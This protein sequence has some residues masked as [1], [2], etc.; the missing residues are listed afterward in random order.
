MGLWNV[1]FYHAI[2]AL[3]YLQFFDRSISILASTTIFPDVLFS[4]ACINLEDFYLLAVHV[5]HDFV[6]LPFLEAKA[7]ALVAVV[8]IVGL[9]LVVLDAD[10]I[11]VRR[12]RL[13]GEGY[14]GVDYGS[15]RNAFESPGLKLE[16]SASL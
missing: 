16:M 10:E 6:C 4:S 15:F 11:R 14:E 13:E 1:L 9:I 2:Y 12:C 7:Y 5:L 8:L 3:M